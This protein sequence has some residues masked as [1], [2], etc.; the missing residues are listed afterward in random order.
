MTT[1]ATAS[2]YQT[3]FGAP[4]GTATPWQN[5][6][7]GLSLQPG[8]LKRYGEIGRLLYK[9][10]R[11]D[12][13]TKAG[14]EETLTAEDALG[15]GH[16]ADPTDLASDL[17]AL[18]P[19][20]VKLGQLL[21]TRPDLL[22]PAY[23]SALERL[24]DDVEPFSFADVERIIQEEFGMRISK[25][26]AAFDAEPV[27]AASL[28]QVHR[29]Q[30]RDGRD[31]AIKI[32][33][34][35]IRER[36]ATDVE[37][38]MEIAGFLDRH[39]SAG[40]QF[41]F[42]RLV[43]EFHRTV[44]Q[45]LDYRREAQNLTRIARNLADF[46]RIVIPR[47][48][49]DYSSSRVLT[50]ELV[51]GRKVTSLTPLVRQ[52]IDADGL[53][54]ELFRAYLHQIVI[55]GFFHADPHPGNVFITDDG[56]LALL[57]LGMVSR[58]TPTRQD[59]LLKLLLAIADGHGDRAANLALQMGEAQTTLNE[60]GFRRDVQELIAT[61]QDAPIERIQVGRVMLELTRISGRH[62]LRMPSELAL[63]GKT[64]L[65][66]DQV[67]RTLSPG[68][69]V[70]RGLR[71]EAARLM[72]ERMRR[73][74]SESN[75]FT[76]ALEAREFIEQLPARVNKVLDAITSNQVRLNV[77][78]I[79]EGA[80]ITGLQKVANRITLGLLLASLILGAAMLMRVETRFR[81]FGYPGFAMLFFLAAA[82]GA[83]WLAFNI[84]R[85]DSPGKPPR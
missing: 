17:E 2:V 46:P 28:G 16:A 44:M 75:I 64:L 77:E 6:G 19:A 72:Q 78:L 70:N 12:L 69:D 43:H 30:L 27:A 71:D 22:P 40:P 38:M 74:M 3:L 33:R 15:S 4:F 73:S 32:Q 81:L 7:V 65:N 42:V 20:F 47:P 26:F 23:L 34:P 76:A 51:K 11:R 48:V 31:V 14:L 24:Q 66:L 25:G 37:T 56:R 5:V 58:L 29:A 63:L 57:D 60:A 1:A 84:L 36:M 35:G 85:S 50:M 39:T 62:G 79:D 68:F 59:Q 45:E 18:G 10:G 67:G 13:V 49:D 21:S 41:D 53:A 52:E 61:Y 80:I 82:A 55:D 8:R 54:L 9:Y 83:I